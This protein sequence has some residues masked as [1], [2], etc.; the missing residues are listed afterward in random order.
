MKYLTIIIGACVILAF[1]IRLND[2]ACMNKLDEVGQELTEYQ[3]AFSHGTLP[4]KY[5]LSCNELYGFQS[6][7][8]DFDGDMYVIEPV[9]ENVSVGCQIAYK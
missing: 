2:N 3:F 5:K 4:E 7:N 1:F 9:P 6:L 8:V